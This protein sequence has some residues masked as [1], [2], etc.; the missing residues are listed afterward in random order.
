M[1]LLSADEIAI[2]PAVSSHDL[3]EVPTVYLSLLQF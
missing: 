1:N 3:V 2:A